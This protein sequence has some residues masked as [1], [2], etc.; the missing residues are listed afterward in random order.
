MKRFIFWAL[1]LS[2][3]INTSIASAEGFR[4]IKAVGQGKNKEAALVAA[5]GAA[6]EKYVAGLDS[7]RV[8]LIMAVSPQIYA[9]LQAYVPEIVPIGE[10]EKS[11]K[12][13][14]VY[15]MASINEAQ[16][17][18]LISQGTS[19]PALAQT[20]AAESL[21]L[22]F[23][24]VARTVKDVQSFKAREVSR[25]EAKE[26]KTVSESGELTH[27]ASMETGGSF[28]QKGE[29]VGYESCNMTDVNAKVTEVF[30]KANF[31]VVS[32]AE[33]G[34]ESKEFSDNYV[35]NDNLTSEMEMK[36]K[37]AAR[38]K[39]LPLLVLSTMTVGREEIDS[40]SGMKKRTVTITAQ[41]FDTR[42]KFTKTIAS[43]GPI[44]YYGM[45][46]NPS[47]AETNALVTA[48]TTAAKD[49]IDQLRVKGV[50]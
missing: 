35:A 40:A 43:V 19:Q 10:P 31:E 50:H 46:E 23:V 28:T 49:L 30:T 4:Q 17:E 42:S 47:V 32:P 21:P 15:V 12:L 9:N 38:T 39:E 1:L 25:S 41:I 6:F 20:P 22:S 8:Q 29:K 34:L 11:G 14:N 18:Q 13:W 44:Q 36:A 27:S 7:Q 16:I 48:A 33:I 45:G 24:F 5:R 3:F 2:V 26:N 37:N